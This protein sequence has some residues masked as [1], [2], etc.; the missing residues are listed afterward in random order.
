VNDLDRN[1]VR[2]DQTVIDLSR[3]V[4]VSEERQAHCEH[5]IDLLHGKEA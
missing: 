1:I 5:R 2:V 4:A 3:R